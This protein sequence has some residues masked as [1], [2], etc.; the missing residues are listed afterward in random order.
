MN[1]MAESAIALFLVGFAV[2]VWVLLGALRKLIL[3]A[4]ILAV[5]ML[6][7]ALRAIGWVF[8]FR[9]HPR[10]RAPAAG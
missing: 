2:A 4:L 3:L 6:L 5:D 8:G 9:Y 10:S 7:V 1:L